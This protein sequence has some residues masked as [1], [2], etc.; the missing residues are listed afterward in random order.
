MLKITI[1]RET[2]GEVH[3]ILEGK[4]AEQWAA[5]LDGVCRSHLRKHQT[6]Q[7]DCAHV[8][9]VDAGGV[10]VLRNLPLRDV[11]L[12]RA[13]KFITQLLSEGDAP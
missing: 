3:L 11:K 4:I 13:P 12:V 2:V 10:E 1:T 9:F 8:E 6:V 5:L 7:L